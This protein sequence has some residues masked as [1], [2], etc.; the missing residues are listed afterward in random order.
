MLSLGLNGANIRW[1]RA[2]QKHFIEVG[3]V[4]RLSRYG[5][6]LVLTALPNDGSSFAGAVRLSTRPAICH[7]VGGYSG[8]LSS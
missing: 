7:I 4:P 3:T 1:V 8:E 6:L 2:R 5:R